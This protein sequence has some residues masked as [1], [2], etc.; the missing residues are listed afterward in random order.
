MRHLGSDLEC[1]ETTTYKEA[2]IMNGG[3][4][5]FWVCRHCSFE[6]PFDE[7]KAPHVKSTGYNPTKR[8]L[9]KIE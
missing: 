7:K 2:R 6:T 1:Y 9:W 8:V 3:G 4:K 5:K